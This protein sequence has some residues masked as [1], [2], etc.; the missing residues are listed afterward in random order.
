MTM[1]R[2]LFVAYLTVLVIGIAYSVII[3]LAGR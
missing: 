1:S 2:V 3:G